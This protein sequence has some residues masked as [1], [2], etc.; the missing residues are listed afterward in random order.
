[1][2]LFNPLGGKECVYI[3]SRKLLGGSEWMG[4][5]IKV[6]PFLY[7]MAKVDMEKK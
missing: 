7:Q 6:I 3:I 2:G 4:L 5:Q 1:M